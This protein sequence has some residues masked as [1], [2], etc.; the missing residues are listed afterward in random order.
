MIV[1]LIEIVSLKF[2]SLLAFLSMESRLDFQR[3]LH[4]TTMDK[5]CIKS[6]SERIVQLKPIEKEDLTIQ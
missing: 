6:Y 5:M 1:S 2:F 4:L 3:L